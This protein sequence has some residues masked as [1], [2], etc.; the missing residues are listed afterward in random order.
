MLYKYVSYYLI[1]HKCNMSKI[2][3]LKKN[4]KNSS[5]NGFLQNTTIQGLKFST[6]I[7]GHITEYTYVRKDIRPSFDVYGF[8]I[9]YY[10]CLQ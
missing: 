1:L 10:F 8:S 7:L 9:S 3:Y 2:K 4:F 6:T 5:F